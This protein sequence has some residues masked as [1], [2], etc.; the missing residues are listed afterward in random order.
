MPLTQIIVDNFL[1]DFSQGL[2]I[3]MQHKKMILIVGPFDM[4]VL[5]L[6]NLVL[7]LICMIMLSICNPYVNFHRHYV[8]AITSW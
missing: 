7:K 3:F 6:V 5:I 1:D 4:D 2:C 8:L